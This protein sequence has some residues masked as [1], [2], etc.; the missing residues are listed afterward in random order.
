MNIFQVTKGIR[1][2]GL[3]FGVPLWFVVCGPGI[4][5]KSDA[6]LLDIGKQGLRKRDWVCIIN[7][8]SEL[9]LGTFIEGLKYVG[10]F[11]EVEGRSSVAA[12]MFFNSVDRWTI[13][14][15]GKRIFNLGSLRYRGDLLLLENKESLEEFL[16]S[17][18]DVLCERGIVSE[19]MDFNILFS[20]KLRLYKEREKF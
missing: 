15:D 5:Y 9:G 7:G 2:V 19:D 10:A 3:N 6:L 16:T 18:K 1:Q 13:F 17:T 12:P 8:Q 20:N 4:S 14:W 11:V